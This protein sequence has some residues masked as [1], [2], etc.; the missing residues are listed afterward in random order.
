AQKQG[1]FGSVTFVEQVENGRAAKP[2]FQFSAGIREIFAVFDY[3]AISPKAR[4]SWRLSR[5]GA[6]VDESYDR[7]W[8]GKAKS[9][10][11]FPVKLAGQPGIYD[12]DLYLDGNLA[13][14]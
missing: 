11:V 3:S 5:E 6:V 12:L 7:I 10:Y 14:L 2:T 8:E 13:R 1:S 9:T 4:W